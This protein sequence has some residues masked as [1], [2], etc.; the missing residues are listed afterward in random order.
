[1]GHI[2]DRIDSIFSARHYATINERVK[3]QA[4][5]RLIS[6][7]ETIEKIKSFDEDG[8]T[9]NCKDNFDGIECCTPAEVV[10]AQEKK[11]HEIQSICQ[12]IFPPEECIATADPSD[13][14][15]TG[16]HGYTA[17]HIAALAG[18]M[19]K[20]ESLIR[21]GID[22]TIKDSSGHMAWQKAE[23]KHPENTELIWRLKP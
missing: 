15:S 22:I 8:D 16:Q 1:V 18:D 13:I 11:I 7:L 12:Y 17:L 20:C 2:K 3:E 19:E 9:P 6:T 23:Y 5:A 4:K 14:N 21:A 10:E